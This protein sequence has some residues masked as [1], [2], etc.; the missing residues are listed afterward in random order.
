MM[1][2]QSQNVVKYFTKELTMSESGECVVDLFQH[3]PP[4]TT[5][6]HEEWQI[7]CHCVNIQAVKWNWRNTTDSESEVGQ[8]K[9]K[10][11][12]EP[13]PPK[14]LHVGLP[15]I[16]YCSHSYYCY[17]TAQGETKKE[18]HPLAIIPIDPLLEE[19]NKS[20]IV[21]GN[22]YDYSE[23]NAWVPFNLN[24]NDTTKIW[25]QFPSSRI[26]HERQSQHID[27]PT[28]MRKVIVT[29]W[30]KFQKCSR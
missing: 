21:E 17:K 22:N 26:S 16:A 7:A 28:L 23:E 6:Q 19:A 3:F 15:L 25:L 11:P 12:P 8:G 27:L 18:F 14:L 10:P 20:K 29:L 4:F 2:M 1:A 5:H 13:K 9:P 24:G 30:I